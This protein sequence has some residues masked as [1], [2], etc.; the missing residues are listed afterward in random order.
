MRE[1]LNLFLKKNK[2]EELVILDIPLL[3]ENKLNKKGDI[4]IFVKSEQNKILK[5][6]KKRPN[7]SLKVLKKLK[8]NQS[9]LSKKSKLADYTVD[10]N[11]S[12]SIMKKKINLLKKKIIDERNSIRY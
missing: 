7:F 1:R 8:E 6:L 2:K 9:K 5:R 3:I 4:L 12:L 10:N 11:F